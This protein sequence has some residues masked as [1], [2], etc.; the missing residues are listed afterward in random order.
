MDNKICVAC[1]AEK[2][3]NKFR[4]RTVKESLYVD[5]ICS[6]CRSARERAQLKLDLIKAFGGRCNCCGESHPAF[7]TLEHKENVGHGRPGARK[8]H[9]LLRD[10]KNDGWDTTKYELLCFNCNCAKST[11]GQCPHRSGLTA[12]QELARLQEQADN[13]IGHS[14][15][16]M[17]GSQKGW[18]KLG[19]DGRRPSEKV[20]DAS[21]AGATD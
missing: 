13:K 3:I 9:Q 7:L 2:P 4:R 14:H 15:K 19:F 20:E 11:R 6:A 1:G 21:L 12:E 17:W 10:A 16:N 5:N 8:T 18:F